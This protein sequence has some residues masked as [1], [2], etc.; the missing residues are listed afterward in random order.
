MEYTLS[1]VWMTLPPLAKPTWSAARAAGLVVARRQRAGPDGAIADLQRARRDRGQRRRRLGV[2]AK[3]ILTP[4]CIFCME[5][6]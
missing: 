3:V 1:G 5:N 4:P 2:D 6:H